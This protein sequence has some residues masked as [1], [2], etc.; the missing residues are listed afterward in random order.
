MEQSASGALVGVVG[1]FAGVVGA[2]AATLQA[3]EQRRHRGNTARATRHQSDHLQQNRPSHD[4]SSS[5]LRSAAP[6]A[7]DFIV[8][9]FRYAENS[10]RKVFW[11]SLTSVFLELV[12]WIVLVAADGEQVTIAA[13]FTIVAL[14][15][16]L[17][18]IILIASL[19]LTF[20]ELTVPDA[21]SAVLAFMAA[22]ISLMV[23]LSS[24]DI[25]GAIDL[26]R[27]WS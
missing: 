26:S 14:Y 19:F 9:G 12:A 17:A 5:L 20:L 23:I 3:L 7:L 11:A 4:R 6:D 13:W 16:T 18:C 1:T 21:V 24:L 8:N 2:I 22:V 25:W 10:S 27:V 15:L